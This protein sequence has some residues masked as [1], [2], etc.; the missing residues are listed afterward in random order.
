MNILVEGFAPDAL[1]S[2]GSSQLKGILFRSRISITKA[3]SAP[4]TSPTSNVSTP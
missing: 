1:D 2:R 3:T 4:R